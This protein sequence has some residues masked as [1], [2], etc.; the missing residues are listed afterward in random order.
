[1][2]VC[3]GKSFGIPRSLTRLTHT[4][5][6]KYLKKK[7]WQPTKS[8]SGVGVRMRLNNLH[9]QNEPILRLFIIIVSI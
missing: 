8:R 6:K 3:C 4:F 9:S 2:I 5:K 1:M 7:T